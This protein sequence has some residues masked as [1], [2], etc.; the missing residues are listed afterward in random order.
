MSSRVGGIASAL[1]QN[2]ACNHANWRRTGIAT[3][4]QVPASDTLVP[5]VSHINELR[6]TTPLTNRSVL[7]Q[8][9]PAAH[10]RAFIGRKRLPEQ[11][12]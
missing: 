11:L 10:D 2:S 12:C 9:S 3:V 4:L 7:C 8:M 5:Y 1:L 6:L